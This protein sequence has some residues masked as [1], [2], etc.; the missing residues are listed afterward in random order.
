[1]GSRDHGSSDRRSRHGGSP[2]ER[3]SR[4]EGFLRSMDA[5]G[6][7]VLEPSEIPEERRR[8]LRYMAERAGFDPEKPVRLDQVRES[9]VRRYS[10]EEGGAREGDKD[11]SSDEPEPLVPGFGV[12][13]ETS[14]VPAFGER[15]D[16][17]SLISGG[18]SSNGSSSRS[19]SNK[20]PEKEEKIRRFA[21]AM[22]A[23]SDRNHNGVLER[24][25]WR[26]MRVAQGADRNG[27][28]RITKEEL[29]ARLVE[30]SG[31]RSRDEDRDSS[32]SGSS[33][34]SGSSDS[35]GRTRSYRFSTATERLI[36]GLPDWFSRYDV[37]RDGQVAMAEYSSYWS[38]SKAREFLSYDRNGDGLITQREA[39]GGP[40]EGT[41]MAG[42]VPA[43]PAP[44]GVAPAGPAGG[45]SADKPTGSPEKA[46]GA[47]K[48]WWLQ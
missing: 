14:R 27:D 25:E 47:E 36:E 37:N 40:A 48:P 30:Y 23:R 10:G 38:E 35:N 7:G 43:G 17:A 13:Q 4:L 22:F 15:V 3:A 34:E 6:N 2:E 26:E 39:A 41:V 42:P 44:G 5:N 45:P 19:S 8:M 29:T 9:L 32:R 20:D 18:A 46:G 21:E 24:E 33:S 12:E 11:K 1:M 16:Y 31:R 28:G